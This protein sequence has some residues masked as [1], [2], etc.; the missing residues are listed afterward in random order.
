MLFG[1]LFSAGYFNFLIMHKKFIKISG[2]II[3]CLLIILVLA[4]SA[5]A[6]LL[7]DKVKNNIGLDTRVVG[8]V[9]GYSDAD[10]N[11]ALILVQTVINTFLSV[12]GVL[13][14]VYILYAGYN[15]MTAHGDEEKV[16][17]AKDTIKRAIMGAIIIVA[18]YAISFFVMSRLEKG[19]LK[20]ASSG[21]TIA[22]SDLNQLN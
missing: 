10:A 3:F 1:G 12:I 9:G 14:L 5:S 15:W 8:D 4:D 16:E 2:S 7:N 13:L 21:P 19:T 17:K 6:G 20:G 11:S 22:L 18:A